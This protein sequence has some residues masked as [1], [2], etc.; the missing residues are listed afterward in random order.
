MNYY[1]KIYFFS[2]FKCFIYVEFLSIL[3]SDISKSFNSLKFKFSIIPISDIL[4]PHKINASNFLKF[5][6]FNAFISDILL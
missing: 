1:I 6:F 3:L 5:T 4:L 2:D